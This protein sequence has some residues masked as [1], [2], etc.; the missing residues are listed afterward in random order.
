MPAESEISA[1]TSI[2]RGEASNF[3][4]EQQRH[5]TGAPLSAWYVT[6][7]L[8]VN[9]ETA[10]HG[11]SPRRPWPTDWVV[12]EGLTRSFGFVASGFA[13]DVGAGDQGRHPEHRS[14][15]LEPADSN[16]GP[17]PLVRL[18]EGRLFPG[19]RAIAS[20]PR[21]L[22]PAR[23][24]PP[25]KFS[26]PPSLLGRPDR[27]SGRGGAAGAGWASRFGS[28]PAPPVNGGATRK[29]PVNEAG[30]I[31][32]PFTGL[33]R[34]GPWFTT[35][36]PG[37]RRLQIRGRNVMSVTCP[38]DWTIRAGRSAHTG[39][40]VLPHGRGHMKGL[41]TLLP[42]HLAKALLLAV[43]GARRFARPLPRLDARHR[44][45]AAAPDRHDD[46]PVRRL[47]HDL[48]PAARRLRALPHGRPDLL[49][50][51]HDHVDPGLPSASSPANATSA[52]TPP[53]WP[54]TRC[55]PCSAP[56]SISRWAICS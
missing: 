43:P 37:A 35:G 46:D 19:A 2:G 13:P 34:V 45:V 29:S 1:R 20:L 42:G 38:A 22:N 5:W 12:S 40:T 18:G 30:G 48:P 10:C 50:V 28:Q 33:R 17:N 26:C 54:S 41:L 16:H 6:R 11:R 15:C 52:S 23:L 47:L 7:V 36:R 9:R 32:A 8:S 44:L 25:D 24:A 53:R 51:H 39:R 55:G 27:E 3:G 56:P 21:I 14:D 31:A 4:L 49:A